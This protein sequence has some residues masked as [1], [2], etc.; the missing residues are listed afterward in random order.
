M[1]VLDAEQPRLLRTPAYAVGE[2]ALS[3]ERVVRVLAPGEAKSAAR[4]RITSTV[5]WRGYP[6][7]SARM[8]LRSSSAEHREALVRRWLPSA[9]LLEIE[10]CSLRGLDAPDEPVVL[11]VTYVEEGTFQVSGGMILGRLSAPWE[12][13]W[14][15]AE[16]CATRRAPFRLSMATTLDSR[17]TVVPPPGYRFASATPADAAG[18]SP[19]GVWTCA[20]SREGLALRVTY[21]HQSTNGRH[22]P[23]EYEDFVRARGQASA[24]LAEALRLE[25]APSASAV[26]MDR[27]Q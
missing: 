2:N 22:A 20:W 18:D 3:V 27:G 21:R 1:L 11:H 24:P 4:A 23:S 14:L 15:R 19:F 6:A 17:T 5:S 26:P 7:A 8:A 25:E 10:S 9:G 12:D 16:P 13:P